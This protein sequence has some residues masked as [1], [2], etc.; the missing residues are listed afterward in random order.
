MTFEMHL[1]V[2][3]IENNIVGVLKCIF[4]IYILCIIT[5]QT[6]EIEANTSIVLLTT[7]LLEKTFFCGSVDM[8]I[9]DVFVIFSY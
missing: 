5:R 4:I 1:Q 7:Y 9:F 2:L 8:F 6:R 3:T